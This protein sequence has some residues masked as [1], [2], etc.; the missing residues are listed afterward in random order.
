MFALLS[1]WA[2]LATGRTAGP[3]LYR[4]GLML[5]LCVGLAACAAR[6]ELPDAANPDSRTAAASYRPVLS[7]YRPG[8]PVEP[9]EWRGRNDAVTPGER[10]Q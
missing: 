8:R 3:T 9:K 6:P 10:A 5:A 1:A 4:A 7:G 2:L